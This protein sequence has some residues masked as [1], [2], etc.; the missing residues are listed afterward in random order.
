MRRLVPLLLL[1]AAACTPMAWVKSDVTAEQSEADWQACRELAWRESAWPSLHYWAGYPPYA[2]FDPFFGRT[3]A[4][5]LYSPF[6]DRFA[7]EARLADVCMRAKG[8][9][10]GPVRK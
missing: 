2:S 5:P 9:E 8:Y 1:A 10:L 7:E 6:G 4:W 3:Y